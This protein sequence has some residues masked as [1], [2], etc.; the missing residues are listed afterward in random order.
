MQQS[1]FNY[2]FFGRKLIKIE[3]KLTSFA[4]NF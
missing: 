2:A 3:K 4:K 1:G